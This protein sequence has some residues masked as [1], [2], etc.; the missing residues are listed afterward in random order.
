[1]DALRRAR[2]AWARADFAP[3]RAAAGRAAGLGPWARPRPA[4]GTWLGEGEALAVAGRLWVEPM[5]GT[6]F[7]GARVLDPGWPAPAPVDWLVRAF[8]SRQR[9]GAVAPLW[10]GRRAGAVEVYADLLPR[11]AAL[12]RLGVGA[13]VTALISWRIGRLRAV[14]AA[15]A[16]GVF[17]PR[18]V[19]VQGWERLIG[20]ERAVLLRPGV[21]DAA[22][23][24][25]RLRAAFG[26]EA[27]GPVWLCLLAEA[28]RAPEGAKAMAI[29]AVETG[30]LVRRA[31]GA[32][33]LAASPGATRALPVLAATRTAT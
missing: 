3:L 12:E 16:A 21:G 33:S 27:G 19:K 8:P 32:E 26:A 2:A 10:F 18:P 20:A 14:Q 1:V 31:A 30:E 29:D 23:A 24:G 25:A 9:L 5:G 13:E 6:V 11:A 15:L 17:A 4:A 22:R 28:G 7:D